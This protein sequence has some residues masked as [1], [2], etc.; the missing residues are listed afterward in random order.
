M[1]PEWNTSPPPWRKKSCFLTSSEGENNSISWLAY[2]LQFHQKIYLF[3]SGV[4][5]QSQNKYFPPHPFPKVYFPPCYKIP[6][7]IL[8]HLLL[9]CLFCIFFTILSLISLYLSSSSSTFL[10]IP[11]FSLPLFIFFPKMTSADIPS[12]GGL[13]S[14]ILTPV[15]FL[16]ILHACT[17]LNWNPNKVIQ[18]HAC[19]KKNLWLGRGRGVD[20]LEENMYAN[21]VSGPSFQGEKIFFS[22]ME[23]S[24]DK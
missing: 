6:I 20:V 24:Y 1:T 9:F 4:Y 12:P 17:C 23:S 19:R 7:F 11:P 21:K 15:L 22:E 10:Y 14:N 18:I 16:Y 13:F 2:I 8:K 5:Y 3:C